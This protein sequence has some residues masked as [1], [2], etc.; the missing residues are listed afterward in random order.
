MANQAGS[1]QDLREKWVHEDN[2][3][4]HRLTW[5]LVSQT[6]M[7]AGYGVLLDSLARCPSANQA[8]HIK[9]LLTYLPVFGIVTSLLILGSIAAALWAMII[10]RKRNPDLDVYR[11]ATVLGSL[12]SIGLPLVF[13]FAWYVA[14]RSF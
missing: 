4:D 11:G 10:L 2:L 14:L 9:R 8:S 3:V 5:L 6:L 1:Y 13:A 12:A 7:F